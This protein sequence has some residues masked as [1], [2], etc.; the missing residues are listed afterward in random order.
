MKH[1]T[2][3]ALGAALLF[4]AGCQ[5]ACPPAPPPAAANSDELP[6]FV[7]T[8]WIGTSAGSERGTILVFLPDK[9][10]LMDSCNGGLRVTQWGVISANRIRVLESAV[11]IEYEYSQ[12]TP[13]VLDLKPVGMDVPKSYIRATVPYV[14]PQG[15]K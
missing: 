2:I 15:S 1:S 3:N 13:Q 9:T 8:T 7:G 11:P 14:C 12:L 6:A 4:L 5:Q 10:V